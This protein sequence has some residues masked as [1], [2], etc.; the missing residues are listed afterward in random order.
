MMALI[1]ITRNMVLQTLKEFDRLGREAMLD[2]F[3]SGRSGKSTRW[4][5]F[6]D[7]R[8]YDQK[9][10]LRAAHQLS[11]LGPLPSGRGT[12]KASEARRLLTNLGFDV[13]D[14]L[15]PA[16]E[17]VTT[18][19]DD[20][21]EVHDL[22]VTLY[23]IVDRLEKIFPGRK[24]TLDGHLVGSIGEVL[25]AYMFGLELLPN[26][27]PIHDAVTSEGRKIQIKLTQ[28][29]KGVAL[30]AQPDFLL[31]LR[32]TPER[33]VEIIYNGKGKVP[34]SYAGDMQKNGQRQISLKRLREINTH[35]QSRDRIPLVNTGD[36][37]QM[38][39]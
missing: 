18:R 33:R 36:L 7:G 17:Q 2:K 19:S 13:V 24:F 37:T 38:F 5:I 3:S 6:F 32:L 27:S 39:A 28:S 1:E 26:S 35:V 29:A 23:K 21:R 25:A 30:R 8:Y 12:F 11:G 20:W 4:Y 34:W 14:N 22:I 10:I 31:V 16:S 15:Q 9:L